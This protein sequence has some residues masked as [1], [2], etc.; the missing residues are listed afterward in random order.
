MLLALL[1]VADGFRHFRRGDTLTFTQGVVVAD[2]AAASPCGSRADLEFGVDELLRLAFASSCRLSRGFLLHL[3]LL[4][5]AHH[6]HHFL[7]ANEQL[8]LI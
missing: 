1:V 2:R 8:L 7:L 6:C 5:W 3:L 4:L